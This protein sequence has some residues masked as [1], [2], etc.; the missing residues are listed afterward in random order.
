MPKVK[1]R[2]VSSK[3]LYKKKKKYWYKVDD[4]SGAIKAI[5]A[6]AKHDLDHNTA[7]EIFKNGIAEKTIFAVGW[8]NARGEI[9]WRR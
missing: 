1:L 7:Q 2:Q 6:W 9:Y 8:M 5:R 3:E 4:P